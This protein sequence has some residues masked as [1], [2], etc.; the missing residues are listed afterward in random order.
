MRQLKESRRML[1]LC[2]MNSSVRKIFEVV[3]LMDMF[4]IL[5]NEEDALREFGS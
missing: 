2:R 4:D 1:K 3:E 5:D